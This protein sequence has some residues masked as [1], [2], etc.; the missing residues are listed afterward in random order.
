[1]IDHIGLYIY[2]G[3]ISPDGMRWRG[4]LNY[5]PFTK[6][7]FHWI[8]LLSKRDLQYFWLS[9]QKKHYLNGACT[10][11]CLN[12]LERINDWSDVLY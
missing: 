12:L 11:L 5:C 10:K 6:I 2:H 3:S 8:L 4:E 7:D 1:M 9:S